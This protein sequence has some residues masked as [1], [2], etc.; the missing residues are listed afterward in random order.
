MTRVFSA[1]QHALANSTDRYE[2]DIPVTLFG[3][4]SNLANATE[5]VIRNGDE[6]TASFF[7]RPLA[8][9]SNDSDLLAANLTTCLAT[10]CEMTRRPS[11]CVDY[12]GP[13]NLLQSPTEFDFSSGLFRCANKLCSNT[14]GLP[15]ANQD[16]FGIGVLISYYVQAVLLLALAV[17]VSASAAWQLFRFVTAGVASFFMSPEEVD[18]LNGYALLAVSLMGCIAPVFTLLLLHSHGIKSWQSTALCLASWL[19][20]TVVFYMLF[21]NLSNSL[22]TIE[23][24]DQVLRNLF[25]TEYCGNSSAMV[26][27]QE[28]TGS[29]P[30]EYLTEF[31]NQNMVTNIHNVP[32]L[33]AYATLVLLVLV[34]M[35][36]LGRR[37]RHTSG[38]ASIKQV[39]PKKQR[40]LLGRFPL[41]SPQCW[42]FVLLLATTTLFSLALSCQYVMVSTYH[43]MDV[44]DTHEWSFGQVVAVLIWVPTLLEVVESFNG[45]KEI[46]RIATGRQKPE[47]S[48]AT[49]LPSSGSRQPLA[50]P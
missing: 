19:L 26:L 36:V 3:I 10:T 42:R 21:G 50:R 48:T 17:A 35:Q 20:N 43:A 9:I 15:F 25:Q 28:W 6:T 23:R 24:V 16:V 5:S 39:T 12:C 11:E 22:N 33:W 44:I 38:C 2:V 45:K 18:P 46:Q 13:E 32:V 34:V 30:V 41:P 4:C 14:C 7:P 31:Y 8:Q 40:T 27:C 47:P 37:D 49:R 29:N 1:S